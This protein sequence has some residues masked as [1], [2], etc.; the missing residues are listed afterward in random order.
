MWLG[1]GMEKNLATG[2]A[3]ALNFAFNSNDYIKIRNSFK[4]VME[5]HLHPFKTINYCFKNNSTNLF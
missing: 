1:Y 4:S 5:K 3:T 2:R